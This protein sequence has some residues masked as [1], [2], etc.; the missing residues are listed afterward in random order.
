MFSRALDDAFAAVAKFNVSAQS[1]EVLVDA[2]SA[3]DSLE[4]K[5]GHGN[6]SQMSSSD[7]SSYS[8]SVQDLKAYCNGTALWINFYRQRVILSEFRVQDQIEEFMEHRCPA[9]LATQSDLDHGDWLVRLVHRVRMLI[10]C[11]IAVD[12]NSKDYFMCGAAGNVPF[13]ETSSDLRKRKYLPETE[14]DAMVLV[15]I[16]RILHVWFGGSSS[17]SSQAKT[18]LVR[19]FIDR[20]GT[21]CLLL[22]DVWRV[23][24]ELPNYLFDPS[25]PKFTNANCKST[26][27]S[28]SHLDDFDME[29]L[30]ETLCDDTILSRI[31]ALQA[32]YVDMYEVT[33]AHAEAELA[34]RST[35]SSLKKLLVSIT[36]DV[37]RRRLVKQAEKKAA[38]EARKNR[39][40][41]KSRAAQAP[42][43]NGEGTSTPPHLS[44][45][46]P[47]EPS[48]LLRPPS[49]LSEHQQTAR[50]VKFL[51]DALVAGNALAQNKPVSSLSKPQRTIFNSGDYF[52]P[53][54]ELGPS[55]AVMNRGF[56]LAFAKTSAG[57]FSIQVFRLIHFNSQAF[58]KCPPEVR[59]VQF[60]DLNEYKAYLTTLRLR[61]RGKP[62]SF[63]CN[64][65]A[66][67]QTVSQRKLHRY[68]DYWDVSKRNDFTWPPNRSFAVTYQ[69]FKTYDPKITVKV[70]GEDEI[71]RLWAGVGDLTRYLLV[72]D[73]CAAGLVDLPTLEEA[74]NVVAFLNRGAVKGLVKLGFLTEGGTG[75]LAR[76]AFA[77]FYQAVSEELSE[78]QKDDFQWNPVTAEHTLC[79]VSRILKK[80]FY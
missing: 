48:E 47:A 54:R 70:D 22:P 50:V 7:L 10:E 23:Y 42:R 71:K 78:D 6:G 68:G 24:D 35:P 14:R 51:G 8:T 56:D 60:D 44:A 37:H 38:E 69:F 65:A 67:G 16:S 27:F 58:R 12:L 53:I 34:R 64:S 49:P 62:D 52:Q 46:S 18:A 63:F 3:M 26:V 29:L 66:H 17:F 79:K 72:A 15:Y 31:D 5:Y 57:F 77:T 1:N 9:I 36:S 55:R 39:A 28:A 25:C 61:F 20:L 40:A 13:Q 30:Q 11:G 43:D 41:Q 76:K 45:D 80:S 4:L 2:L 33:C 73:M 19:V 21:G 75:L 59:Q 32:L 74:A